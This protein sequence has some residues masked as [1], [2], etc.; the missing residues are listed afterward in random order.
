MKTTSPTF[1]QS[2]FCCPHCKIVAAQNWDQALYYSPEYNDAISVKDLMVCKCAHCNDY[3]FWYHKEMV[4]PST[5]LA[6]AP[7]PDMPLDIIDDYKEASDILN[8]SPRGAA[9]LLRLALQKLMKSLGE[10]GAHIDSDIKSLVQK[11]LPVQIQQ[12][13][14]V[15]RVIGNESVHPGSIDM[16]DN[17][18]I[19]IKLFDLINIIVQNQI[20]QPKEIEALFTSLPAGKLKAIAERD[21][22]TK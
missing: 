12:A 4:Y 22:I 19:A 17:R 16:K 14:D 6:P 11:G 1:N 7:H 13:L 20:T 8:K 15:L 18:E 3:S 5:S 10:K 2:S 9:A 21:G